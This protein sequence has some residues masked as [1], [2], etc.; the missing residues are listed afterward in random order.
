MKCLRPECGSLGAEE[1]NI[2]VNY[3]ETE[4][5]EE[6]EYTGTTEYGDPSPMIGT[7]CF[8]CGFTTYLPNWQ[9]TV[10]SFIQGPR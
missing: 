6:V 9:E 4:D 10:M 2:S 1:L 3:S 8:D 5:S 7:V